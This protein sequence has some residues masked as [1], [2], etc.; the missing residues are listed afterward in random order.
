MIGHIK[1]RDVE[2]VSE[3]KW[4]RNVR[5]K[6]KKGIKN[7]NINWKRKERRGEIQ[8]KQIQEQNND[9]TRKK[10]S[11]YITTMITELFSSKFMT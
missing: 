11:I 9:W 7:K 10:I 2:I 5:T 8:H 4:K 6:Q 3:K 1:K